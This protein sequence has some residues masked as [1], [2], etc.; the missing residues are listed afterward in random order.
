MRRVLVAAIAL[1]V[2]LSC[3]AAAQPAATFVVKGRVGGTGSGSRSTAPTASPATAAATTR[4]SSTTTTGA[5]RSGRRASGAF[6]SCSPPRPA[7][8]RSARPRRSPSRTRTAGRST[9]TRA[10]TCSG[11]NL[12]IRSAS[13]R[14]AALA[15]PVRFKPGSARAAALRATATEGCWGPLPGRAALGRQRHR[16]RAVRQGRRRLGD[17]GVV[18]SR[19]AEG[20]GCRRATYGLVSRK[21]GAWFDLYAD[22]RSQVYGG[23]RAEDPRTNA[24][25]DATSGGGR[26]LERRARLDA[27]PLDLGWEDRVARGRVGARRGFPTSWAS[28]D[29]HD[30][31]SPH[32]TWGPLD[33]EDD[34]PGGG[35]DCVWSA[36]RLKRALGGRAPSS[37]RDFTVSARN[38]SE[39]GRADEADGAVGLDL[40]SAARRS[41]ASSACARPGSRSASCG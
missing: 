32:H 3:A 27:L 8:S 18:A 9:W 10:R 13:A 36:G 15:S 2:A 39:P 21:S 5:P 25:V 11:P 23:V 26:P 20:S 34:C 1:V 16:P 14:A 33:A 24:A 4:G 19:G 17:A 35:R 29:P 30:D 37:I 7:R 12:R 22:T 6:A 31:I 28:A 38:G 41:A 40:R